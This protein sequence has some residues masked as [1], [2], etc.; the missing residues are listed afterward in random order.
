MVYA[1]PEITKLADAAVAVCA[2][3]SLTK[4]IVGMDSTNLHVQTNPAYLAEE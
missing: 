2:E 4:A 3:A 1:K